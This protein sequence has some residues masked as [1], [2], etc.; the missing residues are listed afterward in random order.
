MWFHSTSDPAGGVT[1]V[2]ATTSNK[3]MITPSLSRIA[4]ACVSYDETAEHV[5]TAARPAPY[6][7]EPGHGSI[8]EGLHP[9]NTGDLSYHLVTTQTFDRATQRSIRSRMGDQ[10][11]LGVVAASLL[12]YAP[13]RHVVVG[14]DLRDLGQHT[15]P[16]GHVHGHVVSSVG[17]SHVLLRQ[18]GVVGPFPHRLVRDAVADHR[19]QAT[20]NGTGRGHT[21]GPRPV[22][23]QPSRGLGL[24]EHRVV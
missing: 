1:A 4:G 16:A 2:S 10:H 19:D 13:D 9:H 18:P 22:E 5:G 14:E 7:L 12:A 20:Q 8:R 23:H 6:G 24:D 11:Q 15:G 21:S 17:L 3:S